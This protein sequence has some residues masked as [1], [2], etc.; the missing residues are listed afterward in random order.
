[1]ILRVNW[2]SDKSGN[3][4]D[5]H[6]MLGIGRNNHLSFPKGPPAHSEG[7]FLELCGVNKRSVGKLE[8]R[9]GGCI[10]GIALGMRKHQ[11]WSGTNR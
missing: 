8:K 2:K 10:P 4:Y 6:T 7:G 5:S 1:M 9:G 3:Q 11:I